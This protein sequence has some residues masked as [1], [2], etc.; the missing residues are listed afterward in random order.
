MNND[1][2]FRL[3]VSGGQFDG[4]ACC[5]H[6][7][8][9][10]API[11]GTISGTF[12]FPIWPAGLTDQCDTCEDKGQSVGCCP[13]TTTTTVN[14]TGRGLEECCSDTNGVFQQ[15]VAIGTLLTDING[16]SL[17]SS[18]LFIISG[19]PVCARIINSPTGP[20]VTGAVLLSPP[21]PTPCAGL[22][23]WLPYQNQD[24]T[25]RIPCCPVTTTTTCTPI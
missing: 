1:D 19:V 13:T 6:K 23:A 24:P 15:Y 4:M 3:V 11:V 16:L 5:F 21:A 25:L 10:C 12:L 9:G 2:T 17:G 22:Q 7:C 8:V 18:H 20:T 14:V